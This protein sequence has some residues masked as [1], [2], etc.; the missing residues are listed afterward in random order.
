ML[1]G[2]VDFFDQ[3]FQRFN[4]R[5]SLAS[6]GIFLFHVR[7]D[8]ARPSWQGK[9]LGINSKRKKSR[10]NINTAKQNTH[11][12]IQDM[13]DQEVRAHTKGDRKQKLK[14]GSQLV[15]VRAKNRCQEL[16]H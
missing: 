16:S 2:S 12:T 5:L 13:M 1:T 14:Q 6:R 8:Q 9:T 15:L 7:E 10:W 3:S 4:K 11:L